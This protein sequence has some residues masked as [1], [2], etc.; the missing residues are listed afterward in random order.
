MR[1]RERV[2]L[3]TGG[4]RGIGRSCAV[5]LAGEGAHVAIGDVDPTLL[6]D[7]LNAIEAAGGEGAAFEM[8]VTDRRQIDRVVNAVCDRFGRIDIL[9]NNAGIYEILS[10]E[11]ITE[12]QWDR[13]LAVNL[14]GVFLCSQAVVGGMKAQRGG[15]IINMSSSAGKTGGVLCGAHY[16][17]SKAGIISLTKSLA[18]EVGPYGITVNAIAP[19]RIATP[20]IAAASEEEN[21]A[22]RQQTPLRRLGTPADVAQAVVFLASDDAGYITGEVID[23][24]GGLLMD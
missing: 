8:D 20:M 11:E 19:G 4:G 12:E 22:M 5:A 17:V 1:L 16:A 13:L 18:R 10:F 6:D 15:R 21:E 9:V 7:A 2:A 3:V 23:V 24:N 14:K